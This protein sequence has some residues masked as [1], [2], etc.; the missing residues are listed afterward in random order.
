[1]ARF[2]VILDRL[3]ES[4][5]QAIADRLRSAISALQSAPELHITMSIGL[6]HERRVDRTSLQALL[7]RADAALSQAKTSGRDCVQVV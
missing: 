4:D 7:G 2:V 6:T 1:M 3:N 5:A